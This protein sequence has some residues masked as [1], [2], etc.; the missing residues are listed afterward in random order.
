MGQQAYKQTFH[1]GVTDQSQATTIEVTEGA[2]APNVDITVGRTI[3][4][5]SASGVVLD[6]STNAPVP[7]LG[8]TLSVLAGGGNRQRAMGLMSFPVVSD[9]NG[10][11]RIDNMPPGRYQVAV[12][13]NPEPE[14][15]ASQHHST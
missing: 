15:L 1:P 8:F 11:F 6:S 2:E 7:N 14:C 13:R 9:S 5:Y 4:E 12:A 10:Q 3:D